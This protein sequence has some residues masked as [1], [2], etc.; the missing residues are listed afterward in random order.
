MYGI[1]EV[2][3]LFLATTIVEFRMRNEA[4]VATKSQVVQWL[5]DG[6]VPSDLDDFIESLA[7]RAIG[8][9]CGQKL[10]VKT[11]ARKY[12]LTDSQ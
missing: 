7:G 10:M 2:P 1:T 6:L 3:A 4:T 5:R 12:R 8:S 9:L 11:E